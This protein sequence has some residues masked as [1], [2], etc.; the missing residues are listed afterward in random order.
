MLNAI[1]IFR[2]DESNLILLSLN[3]GHKPDACPT[4]LMS[5]PTTNP[6]HSDYV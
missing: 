1:N 6:K 3:K 4:T 5:L 2:L